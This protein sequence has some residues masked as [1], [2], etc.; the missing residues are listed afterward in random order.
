M[1]RS[2]DTPAD[3]P[4][5]GKLV[6][7]KKANGGKLWQ[8]KPRNHRPAG[9]RPRKQIKDSVKAVFDRYGVNVLTDV[10]TDDDAKDG[11]R[12]RAAEITA[13]I[14]GLQEPVSYDREVVDLLAAVTSEILRGHSIEEIDELLAKLSEAWMLGL[15]KYIRGD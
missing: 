10:L 1:A 4:A 11:D 6:A 13:K 5:G 7:H 8:G 9:G 3:T 15:G 14:G 2:L 12:L